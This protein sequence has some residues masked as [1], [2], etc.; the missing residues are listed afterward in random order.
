MRTMHILLHGP[1]TEVGFG[2]RPILSRNVFHVKPRCGIKT[3]AS[4]LLSLIGPVRFET[5]PDLTLA[6]GAYAMLLD[7]LHRA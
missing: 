2:P 4:P 6:F 1:K 5:G 3:T 7:H